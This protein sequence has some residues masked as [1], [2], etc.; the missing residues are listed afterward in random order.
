M[1]RKTIYITAVVCMCLVS[2]KNYLNVKPQG[3]VLPQTDEEFSTI[4]HNRICDVEGGYDEF[5]IGNMDVIA[6]REGCA[7]DLDANI[8]TGSITAY[9]G[10]VINSRQSDYKKIFEIVRDCNIVIEN[11]EGRNTRLADDV[12]A[13]AYAMKGICY[14]NLIRDFCEAWDSENA[15]NQLGMPLVETFDIKDMTTFDFVVKESMIV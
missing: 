11:L 5:V 6:R 1:M 13:A 4:M 3:K 9:A 2:C 10:D 8:M 7:D 12:L 15:Q 14:Y